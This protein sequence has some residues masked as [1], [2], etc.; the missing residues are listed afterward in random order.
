[1]AKEIPLTQGKVAIV[2]DED[3][4]ELAKHKWRFDG[5]YA[6]TV[7]KG[8]QYKIYMHRLIINAS[9]GELVDHKNRDRLDNRRDN[10]RIASYR[11]NSANCKLHS[12]NTSGYKG[13]YRFTRGNKRWRAAVTFNDKQ[14]S[15]G[16]YDNPIDA[17][18][19]YN[20]KA[21]ELFGDYARINIIEGE[22]D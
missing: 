1:M 7:V 22:I 16:Y 2:D 15:L 19:A 13:V 18:K 8:S 6:T 14:I 12:H 3:Y 9:K 10:L 11:E 20:K 21:L 5:R 17:A 4:E